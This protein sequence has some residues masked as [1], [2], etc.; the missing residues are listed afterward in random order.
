MFKYLGIL[1]LVFFIVGCSS[2]KYYE[3]KKEEVTTKNFESKY[4]GS[5]TIINMNRLGGTFFDGEIVDEEGIKKLDIKDEK[6]KFIN[7]Q[8]NQIIASNYKD[9]LLIGDKVI[10]TKNP[11]I[12]AS[13]KGNKIAIVYTNNTIELLDFQSETTLFKE[14]LPLSIANDTRVVNPRFMEKIVLFPTLDGKLLIVSTET[15]KVLKD[16]IID[17]K[18]EFNNPIFLNLAGNTLITAT[19]SKLLTIHNQTLNTKEYEIRDVIMKDNY[20]YLATIDGYI[21]KLD[22]DLNEL[23]KRKYKYAKF[24]TLATKDA[25]IYALESQG[26]LIKLNDD[27]KDET[28]YNFEFDNE[29]RV[30]FLNNRLYFDMEYIELP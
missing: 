6:F 27:L 21:I 14:Y 7:F 24:H 29:N 17:A 9:K 11:V 12:A 23:A 13:I 18:G 2:K 19:A 30:L 1:F 22:L 25:N 15:N 8:N 5:G 20:I 4:T 26:Y 16:I 3:P 28:I 10:N